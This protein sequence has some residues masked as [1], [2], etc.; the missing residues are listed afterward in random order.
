M[1]PKLDLAKLRLDTRL[2]VAGRD[3]ARADGAVNPPL[4]RATTLV[5]G[6]AEALYGGKNKTYALEG[7]AVQEALKA[8]LVA[9]E[10]GAGATLAPSGLAACSLAILSVA[11]K[12]GELLVTDS[13]YGPT[14]R[15]CSGTM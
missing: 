5:Q 12:D 4:H 8:A 14:R 7:M 10:G 6:Q 1:D 2:G 15:F 9:V 13:V 3:P 11:R